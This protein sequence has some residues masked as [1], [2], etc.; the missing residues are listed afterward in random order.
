MFPPE[1][2]VKDEKQR[3]IQ[4]PRD[5]FMDILKEIEEQFLHHEQDCEA[6]PVCQ[7][8]VYRD[9]W[10]NILSFQNIL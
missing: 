7:L 2:L 1:I 4:F 6:P 8:C 3:T 10:D 5:I 9:K